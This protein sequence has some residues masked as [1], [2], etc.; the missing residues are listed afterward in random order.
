MRKFILTF[1][2][3]LTF[4]TTNCKKEKNKD[5]DLFLFLLLYNYLSTPSSSAACSLTGIPNDPF[6]SFQWHLLNDGST[7]GSV[8]GEDIKASSAWNA[9]CKGTG[10]KIVTVD[11]GMDITHEDLSQNYDS[12]LNINFA[13]TSESLFFNTGSCSL[14]GAGCHGTSVS[15]IMSGRDSNNVGISGVAPRS[16]IGARNVLVNSTDSNASRA[17]SENSTNVWVSNNSW[18]AADDT[19]KLAASGSLWQSGIS[20]GFLSGRNGKGSIFFWAAGNGGTLLQSSNTSGIVSSGKAPRDNSN[21]DGQAN[22]HRAFAVAAVGNDGKRASYSEEGANL[23][24]SAPSEGTS[25]VAITTTD[26]STS[27]GYNRTGSSPNYAN[28]NYTNTFNG[29]SAASPVAAGIGALILERNNSLTARDVRVILA[30]GS[31]KNDSSDSDWITNGAGLNFNHKYGFGTVDASLALPLAQN[32]SLLGTEIVTSFLTGP[33]TN[34]NIP[35]NDQTGAL[36]S[37]TV[38]NSGIGKIEF[39]EVSMTVTTGAIDDAGDLYVELISPAGTKARLAV[40]RICTS[41][42]SITYCN[43]FTAWTF[44]ATIFMDESA[45]G[46]WQLRVADVCNKATSGSTSASYT[47]LATNRFSGDGS[48]YT[49]TTSRNTSNTAH[50]LSSWSMRV[51]G[52]AN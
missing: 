26:V 40:P 8:V 52:R 5:L 13:G 14:S 42:S 22:Y 3:L 18:G 35:N 11:D 28:T 47:C 9:G 4:I 10:V 38:S 19:G 23:L 39:V 7:S 51:R 12:S 2:I 46:T 15:G 43:D 17:M 48:S 21:H 36:N 44:G 1:I 31:R 34:S 25:G 50:T 20:S 6:F 24:V 29:T 27:G 45:D 16:K 32:W 49:F 37:L 33:T 30:R 41:N